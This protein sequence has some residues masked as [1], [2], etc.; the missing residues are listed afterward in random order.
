MRKFH[1]FWEAAILLTGLAACQPAPTNRLLEPGV[2]SE[3]AQYRKKNLTDVNYNLQFSIPESKAEPLIGRAE[4]AFK[5]TKG[6]SLVL[7]FKATPEQLDSVKLNGKAAA[8]QFADE[9]IVLENVAW[10]EGGDTISLFFECGDAALNRREDM[11]YTLF[12]P[13]RARTVFPCFDQPDIKANYQLKLQT[14]ADWKAVANTRCMNQTD[15]R[16]ETGARRNFAF[17]KTEPL[18]TYLFSFVAGKLN[19]ETFHRDDREINIY[20][21][22]NDPDKV[23]QCEA[24]AAE[25]F[26]ALEWMEAYTGI[27]YPFNKYD[28]VIVPGFQFGGMEH[29]GA[30]LYNDTRMFLNKGAT[31]NE[32]LTRSSLIA[33]ETAHMWFGDYVTMKWFDDVWTKEVFANY[34]ASRMVEPHFPEVNHQLNFITGYM[35]GAYGEDHTKGSNAIKQNL[36]NLRNAGLVYGNIIYNKSPMVM[37]MLVQTMGEE[38]FKEGIRKYLNTYPYGNATW[39]GL[40]EILDRYTDADLKSWSQSWVNEKGLPMVRAELKENN[41]VVTQHDVWERDML[42]PQRIAYRLVKGDRSE[43][44]YVDLQKKQASV[45]VPEL[46]EGDE[47][48]VLIPNADGKAY[49]LF[50]VDET[51]HT[52]MWQVMK[53]FN[54]TEPQNEVLRGSVLINLYENL[55]EGALDPMEY[56]DQMLEYIK[57]EKNPLLYSLAL[58]YLNNCQRWFLNEYETVERALWEEV[59]NRPEKGF[60][61]QSFR[62]FRSLATSEEAVNQLYRIWKEQRLPVEVTLGESDYMN[63]AYVLAIHYPERAQQIIDEQLKRID[64]ADRRQEFAF[65]S[66]ATAPEAERRDKVFEALL[67]VE[68]RSIEPWAEQALSLL[69]HRLRQEEALKYIR[70][71][72]EEV[73]EVQRTGDIF[74]PR[75]WARATLRAHVSP[76]AA[77]E[78]EAFFKANPNYPEM[79]GNKIKQQ[80]AHLPLS[81]LR[82]H[83]K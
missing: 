78:V 2:S 71:A 32:R 63:M 43:M 72:L 64:N 54:T 56:R 20:H 75:A 76:E 74:F 17:H 81:R 58:N 66:A 30:T 80:A 7:D 36:D 38:A 4:I 25:V 53:R 60:K 57:I 55:R 5:L 12:V 67:E 8:Y 68:N 27:P 6:K 35:P 79:L 24:I 70:P 29:T 48:T 61:L 46:G 41:L 28:V 44:V 11:L 83:G 82:T 62:H 21:R 50:V 77:R 14:P 45:P 37:E 9:H 69:N 1:H 16:E 31:L 51:Q 23:A 15:D 3:L 65:V 22:E 13:D 73:Q 59:M 52:D 33:H 19:N 18:S 26:D 42:W 10:K 47:P 39:D 34:F 49:G 40:I